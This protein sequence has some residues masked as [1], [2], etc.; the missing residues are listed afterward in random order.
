MVSGIWSGDPEITLITGTAVIA[1]VVGMYQHVYPRKR[2]A[3]S[4]F[5]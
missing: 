4:I 2:Y 1:A 3:G 5:Y